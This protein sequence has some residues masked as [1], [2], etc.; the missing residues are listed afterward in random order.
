MIGASS[1]RHDLPPGAVE[2]ET[3]V[4]VVPF[5]DA[6][7]SA[8]LGG[9]ALDDVF[10]RAARAAAGRACRTPVHVA[11]ALVRLRCPCQ[12]A[13][14]A[15]VFAPATEVACAN[16]AD[17]R[18]FGGA[19]SGHDGVTGVCFAPLD[20]GA[21]LRVATTEYLANGGSGLFEP[22]LPAGRV[23]AADSL[24]AAM[25]DFARGGAPCAASP[26][27]AGCS[28]D[29]VRRA[30]AACAD[31]Q[32]A[33]ACADRTALGVRAAAV[34]GYLPSLDGR[35]GAERDGRIRIEAP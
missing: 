12:S 15:A 27:S 31:E 18:A 2:L 3:L 28:A 8:A 34:C 29:L 22:S 30:D 16:D 24:S 35:L 23:R 5:E 21:V 1:L 17:C 9:A 20:P 26:C 7:V 11:G 13:D 33:E 6:V 4:H 32:R 10:E 14:C 25:A 19:C